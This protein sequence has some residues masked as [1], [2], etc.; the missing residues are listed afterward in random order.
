MVIILSFHGIVSGQDD[1]GPL[2]KLHGPIHINDSNFTGE[3]PEGVTGNGTL[4]DPYLISGFWFNTTTSPG[5]VIRN[6]TRHV[7]VDY[8][9]FVNGKLPKHPGI[10]IEN[11]TNV[12][13]R[14]VATYYCTRG[15]EVRNC[16]GIWIGDSGFF[17]SYDGVYVQGRSISIERVLCKVNVENGILVNMSRNVTIS[18]VI[19]ESNTAILG[20]T[21]GIHLVDSSEVEIIDTTTTLN[22]GFGIISETSNGSIVSSGIRIARSYI[23]TNNNGI[24]MMS[25]ANSSIEETSIRYNTNGIQLSAAS[26]S[27]ISKCNFYKNTYGV[28]LSDSS[29]IAITGSDF[30]GNENAVYLDSTDGAMVHHNVFSNGTW[31]AVTIDTWLGRGPPSRHNM[32]YANR[33]YDNGPK[34]FQAMDN[35]ESNSWYEGTEGNL[36]SDH[37]GP[38]H[39]NDSIVDDPYI[40]DGI[41]N[42]TDEYPVAFDKG[43][44]VDDD[45]PVEPD[46]NKKEGPGN[47]FW[48]IVGCSAGTIMVLLFA[49]LMISG[50]RGR[51][52]TPGP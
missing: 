3:L 46:Q 52:P 2:L 4:D 11:S 16:S 19:A 10:L 27:I 25:I 7:V 18:S 20:L 28:F 34:G 51:K 15:V 43:D 21:A 47:G 31:H 45:V 44:A 41:A 12:R 23:D 26:D 50:R 29:G 48:L 35:G 22:Y 1:E 40:I 24:F 32:V 36:W 37:W 8:N 17:G 30:E 13:V 39:D 42:A 6:S 14:N 5:V 33:F 9:L 38:D 49:V